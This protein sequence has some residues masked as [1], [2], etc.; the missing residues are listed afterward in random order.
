M[1]SQMQTAI[2][3]SSPLWKKERNNVVVVAVRCRR[4]GIHILVIEPA[5]ISM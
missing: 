2:L 3:I 5:S 4:G 1:L